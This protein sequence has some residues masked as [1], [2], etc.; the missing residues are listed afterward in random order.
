MILSILEVLA[1]LGWFGIT[2]TFFIG[3]GAA[4]LAIPLV[5]VVVG[6]ILVILGLITILLGAISFVVAWGLWNGR[7]WAW[8]AAIALAIL[9]II[10]GLFT[11]PGGIITI[12]INLVVVY[13]L[14][15]PHV[16]SF[17][18]KI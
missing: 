15:R 12:I 16:K 14:T 8:T 17:F 5:G 1:G 9:G 10:L 11:L 2:S 6:G 4:V 3:A 13:Y 18:G 7:D